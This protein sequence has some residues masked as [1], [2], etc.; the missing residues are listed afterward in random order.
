[1]HDLHH[2]NSN[3]NTIIFQAFKQC[4]AMRQDAN[5]MNYYQNQTRT[6][7]GQRSLTCIDPKV[8]RTLPRDIKNLSVN[9]FDAKYKAFMLSFSLFFFV[10]LQNVSVYD[11]IKVVMAR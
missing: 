6:E 8:W 11:D 2:I 1:M 10:Y 4:I 7:I 5:Q 3:I 9:A